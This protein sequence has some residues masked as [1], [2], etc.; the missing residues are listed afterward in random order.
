MN[1]NLVWNNYHF[2]NLILII[3]EG[4]FR[5]INDSPISY[6]SRLL[7]SQ[8]KMPSY[9]KGSLKHIYSLSACPID[10]ESKS[11]YSFSKN[12]YNYEQMDET[13]RYCFIISLYSSSFTYIIHCF[14]YSQWPKILLSKFIPILLSQTNLFLPRSPPYSIILIHSLV[15]YF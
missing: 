5:V 1:S 3:G 6:F 14:S 15:I 13:K 10:I 11:N 8:Y 7:Y 9:S 4:S 12:Q 2:N